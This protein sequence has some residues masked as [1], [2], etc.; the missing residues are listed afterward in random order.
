MIR[1][2]KE[3][4]TNIDYEI[5]DSTGSITVRLFGADEAEID[6]SELEKKAQLR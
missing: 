3:M 6:E 5:E 4:S 1:R 2:V